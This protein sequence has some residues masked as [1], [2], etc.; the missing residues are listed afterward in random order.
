MYDRTLLGLNIKVPSPAMTEG[1]GGS[2]N[3]ICHCKVIYFSVEKETFLAH[4]TAV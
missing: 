4:R 2:G 3:A 1:R